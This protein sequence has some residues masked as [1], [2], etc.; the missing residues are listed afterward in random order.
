[1]ERTMEDI[2]IDE[3][4]K[5]FLIACLVTGID[6]S[7]DKIE[8]MRGLVDHMNSVDRPYWTEG[9]EDGVII[10]DKHDRP[11]LCIMYSGTRMTFNTFDQDEFTILET[12]TS[13]GFAVINIIDYIRTLE[14]EFCPSILGSE[15]KNAGQE[16]ATSDDTDD[17]NLEDWAL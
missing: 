5:T 10:H 1:M 14:L 11:L 17:T 4:T 16:F 3:K 12:Q 7:Y 13:T 6:V 8:F 9:D 2:Q 15:S